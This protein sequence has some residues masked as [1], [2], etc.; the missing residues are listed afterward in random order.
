MKKITL[1][2]FFTCRFMLQM[3]AQEVDS[4]CFII[5]NKGEIT[6]VDSL[7]L[8]E[9]PFKNPYI[10]VDGSHKYGLQELSCYSSKEGY[11]RRFIDSVVNFPLWYKREVKGKINFYS[12]PIAEYV[13]GT[14]VKLPNGSNFYSSTY[15]K[16]DVFYTQVGDGVPQKLSYKNLQT[17]LQSNQKSMELLKKGHQSWTIKRALTIAG[18]VALLFGGYQTLKKANVNNFEGGVKVSPFVFVG[19]G[20]IFVPFMIESSDSKYK[21]AVEVFNQ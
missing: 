14:T 18:T 17:L 8:V 19:L 2:L 15:T 7:M 9:E 1:A 11:Y 3:N 5:S 6:Y 20:T 16:Y 4:S 21:R 12:K 10:L 13:N